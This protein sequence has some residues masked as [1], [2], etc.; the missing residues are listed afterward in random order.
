MTDRLT[1]S[2][3]SQVIAEV[4]RLSDR[5]DQELDEVQMQQILTELS[6]PPELLDEAVMQVRR[7]KALENQQRRNRWIVGGVV[8]GITSIVAGVIFL[9]QQWQQKLDRI[10]AQQSRLTLSR[11]DGNDRQTI[12]RQGTTEL[13][14]QVML[15]DAPMGEKLALSC[16]WINPS[17]QAVKQNR[18]D[19]QP[20]TTVEWQTNCRYSINANSPVGVWK[21]KMLLGNRT[22]SER[23]F[24]VK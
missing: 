18:Y 9:Q 8:V 13:N 16:T 10:T 11:D 14:Y 19:T 2:Q 3:L 24:E 20:I 23:S 21:V 7:R 1:E 15:K 17:Q 5:K 12:T 4:Q 22:L 6:L